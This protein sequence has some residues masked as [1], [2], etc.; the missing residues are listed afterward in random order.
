MELRVLVVAYDYRPNLGGVASCGYELAMAMS[1]A[2]GM[3]IKVLARSMAES[4]VFDSHGLFETQRMPLSG[5]SWRA[6]LQL[7][8]LLNKEIKS[9]RPDAILSLLWLPEGLSTFLSPARRRLKIPYSIF[10]HGVELMESKRT[11]RKKIRSFFSPLKKKILS[12]AETVFAVSQYT[13]DLA[14]SCGVPAEKLKIVNNGVNPSEFHPEIVNSE[15][16]SEK[17]GLQNKKIFLTVSRL[18]D[19]KGVDVALSAMKQLVS[20]YS[21]V[22][23]LICG[24]GPD[25]VRLQR[26]AFDY[27]LSQNVIFTGSIPFSKRRAYYGL[28]D[29]CILNSRLDEQK[30][31]V[32]GFGLTILEAAACAKPTIGGRS[33]GIVDAIEDG[34]TG[35]L[36][37]PT[38]PEDLARTMADCLANPQKVKDAGQKARER[39]LQF[40][41]WEQS[42]EKILSEMRRHVRD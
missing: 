33:G 15:E 10:V 39:A 8:P 40:F 20:K 14:S 38:S 16:L 12:E 5:K 1:R 31:N 4:E 2:P 9:W 30:P 3:K 13:S 23:Y 28:A 18:E 29:C 24:E 19:Y 21:N 35:W 11:S 37:D 42:A 26:L 22:V 25:K 32:E 17:H 27:G 7:I 6:A 36:V 41:T 34:L